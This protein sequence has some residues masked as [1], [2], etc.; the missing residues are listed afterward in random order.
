VETTSVGRQP[1]VVW[2]VD[3]PAENPDSVAMREMQV[4]VQAPDVPVAVLITLATPTLQD[5]RLY[6]RLM[7]EVCE[8][9][10]LTPAAAPEQGAEAQVL[11]LSAPQ[12]DVEAGASPAS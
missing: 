1:A 10:R 2:T 8:T 3:V 6:Q 5:W 11:L 12:P 7:R 4:L 9:L